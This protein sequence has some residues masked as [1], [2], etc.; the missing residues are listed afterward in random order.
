MQPRISS[1]QSRIPLLA[2]VS[3]L[4]ATANLL[5]ALVNSLYARITSFNINAACHLPN[6]DRRCICRVQTPCKDS[7]PLSSSLKIENFENANSVRVNGPEPHLAIARGHVVDTLASLLGAEIH[8][9]VD[10][11]IQHGS[12]AQAHGVEQVPFRLRHT[13]S[14][15]SGETAECL[16]L[17]LQI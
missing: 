16:S 4:Y 1:L 17:D 9:V 14:M 5:F 15:D 12:A 7:W 6:L 3:S 8:R 13:R 10:V 2:I 11:V